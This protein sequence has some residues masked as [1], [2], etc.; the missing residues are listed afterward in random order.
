MKQSHGTQQKLVDIIPTN[1]AQLQVETPCTTLSEE[2]FCLLR[3]GMLS[4][5]QDIE[6][7]M[8]QTID[9]LMLSLEIGG[10]QEDLA[11]KLIYLRKHL[12]RSLHSVKELRSAVL[13]GL[14]E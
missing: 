13:G 1:D 3:S 7:A 9:A 10:Q 8:Y 11:E 14:G 6:S 12:K 5:E 4:L 2:E